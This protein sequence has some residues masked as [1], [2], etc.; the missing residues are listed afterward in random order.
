M[1]AAGMQPDADQGGFAFGKPLK[2]QPGLFD[3]PALFFN[4]KDLVLGAVLEEKVRPVAIFWRG[5]VDQGDVFLHH[6]AFLNSFAQGCGRL[7]GAGKDHH[8][9]HILI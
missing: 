5:P 2:F 7:L 1:T 9:A 3:T 6:G 4:H 8:A